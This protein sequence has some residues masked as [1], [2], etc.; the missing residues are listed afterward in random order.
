MNAISKEIQS[1]TGASKLIQ[2]QSVDSVRAVRLY[3]SSTSAGAMAAWSQGYLDRGGRVLPDSLAQPAATPMVAAST[4]SADIASTVTARLVTGLTLS[5]DVRRHVAETV[6]RSIVLTRSLRGPA[7]TKWASMLQQTALRDSAIRAR[8]TDPAQRAQF[9]RNAAAQMPRR[10]LMTAREVAETDVRW[11]LLQ[12]V[13]ASDGE[14]LAA[15]ALVEQSV[16]EEIALFE[17]SPNDDAAR[18]ALIERRLAAVR[19]VLDSDAKQAAFDKRLP[20][21]RRNV[22]GW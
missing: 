3:G 9:D 5:E 20:A 22:Q 1:R 14:I 19:G 16:T 8:L 7:L 12:G 21:L 11:N 17:R 10:T 18:N 4:S 15:V 6:E 2:I 13:P